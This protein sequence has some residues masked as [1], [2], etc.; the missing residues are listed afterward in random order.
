MMSQGLVLP[1]EKNG[2]VAFDPAIGRRPRRV[3]DRLCKTLQ[4]V[5][6]C[7]ASYPGIAPEA[8]AR[9][10]ELVISDHYSGCC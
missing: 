2:D 4:E 10:R 1:T 9:N 6:F 5:E 3:G 7:L 8:A